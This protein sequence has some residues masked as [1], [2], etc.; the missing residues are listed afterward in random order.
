MLEENPVSL[1]EKK[2][3]KTQLKLFSAQEQQTPQIIQKR[4]HFSS[5]KQQ[6]IS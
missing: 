1:A 6:K 5:K 2:I 3:L 4:N